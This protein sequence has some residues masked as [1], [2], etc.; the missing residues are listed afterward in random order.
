[1]RAGENQCAALKTL[2]PQVCGSL[3]HD[4]R[5][6][7]DVAEGAA[8]VPHKSETRTKEACFDPNLKTIANADCRLSPDGVHL[9]G[10][11]LLE[12][13]PTE[14]TSADMVSIRE[15]SRQADDVGV[16]HPSSQGEDILDENDPRMSADFLEGVLCFSMAVGSRK[17]NDVDRDHDVTIL[18]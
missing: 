11:P 4:V 12:V 3:I 15:P 16:I 10:K 13:E 18:L 17:V 7:L 6:A 2:E 1:M 9:I 5:L 14:K 8:F